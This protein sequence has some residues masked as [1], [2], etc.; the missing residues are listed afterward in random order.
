MKRS[1]LVTVGIV[2]VLLAGVGVIGTMQ[3]VPLTGDGDTEPSPCIADATIQIGANPAQISLGQ[4]SVVSW[5]VT[6]PA[7]CSSVHISLNGGPVNTTGTRTV[8][9]AAS[10]AFTITASMTRLGVY[11]QKSAS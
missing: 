8:S 5:S 10:S 1:V 2:A 11:Q 7:G 3:R 6:F 9:P 4:S